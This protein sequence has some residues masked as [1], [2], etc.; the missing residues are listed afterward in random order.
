LGI[1]F[2]FV[3]F[4]AAVADDVLCPFLLF[5]I[6]FLFVVVV[7]I[8]GISFSVWRDLFYFYVFSDLCFMGFLF[9][10]VFF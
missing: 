3:A 5:P 1:L 7:A 9:C 4:V 2:P 10:F 8:W 6:V